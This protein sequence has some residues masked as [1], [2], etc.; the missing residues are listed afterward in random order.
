ML[1]AVQLKNVIKYTVPAFKVC[2]CIQSTQY[3]LFCRLIHLDNL[4]FICTKFPNNSKFWY[5]PFSTK[6][7]DWS[8]FFFFDKL[9]GN[10]NLMFI[11]N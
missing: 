11:E 9:M 7:L 4:R 5:K 10:L 2:G 6:T 3:V 1:L 8:N